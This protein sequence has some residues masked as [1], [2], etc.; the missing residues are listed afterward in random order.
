MC[1][2]FRV[3]MCGVYSM[4]VYMWCGYVCV[5]ICVLMCMLCLCVVCMVCTCVCMHVYVWC[6]WCVCLC[7]CIQFPG[8]WGLVTSENREGNGTPLQYSCLAN[9]MD[10]GAWWAAVDGVAELGV[11]EWLTH[12]CIRT[13][14]TQVSLSVLVCVC[15]CVWV[16]LY[17]LVC[18]RSV[19]SFLRTHDQWELRRQWEPTPVFL[20][21][22]SNGW[23]SLVGC[24][25]WGC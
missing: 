25:P 18:M 13:Q 3:C 14:K 15:A 12:T 20:P 19:F 6:V 24:S 23:R 5:C 4:C 16:C 22:K 9:P 21:G 2:I 17:V 8:F 7:V 10:G 11:T 1:D